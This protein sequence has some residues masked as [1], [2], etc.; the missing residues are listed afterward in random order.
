MYRKKA[1]GRRR[2]THKTKH[3]RR[4]RGFLKTLGSIGKTALEFAPLAIAALGRKKHNRFTRQHR[5]PRIPIASGS[6]LVSSPFTIL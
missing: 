3:I 5:Y 1:C 4:G 2:R 6:G